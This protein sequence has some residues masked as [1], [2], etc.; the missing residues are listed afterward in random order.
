MRTGKQPDS[1]HLSVRHGA[2]ASRCR[3]PL[4]RA[5]PYVLFACLGVAWLPLFADAQV[6]AAPKLDPAALDPGPLVPAQDPPLPEAV[7]NLLDAPPLPAMLLDPGRRRALLIHQL[8]LLPIQSLA[9]PTL[10][11]AGLRINPRTHGPHA[12][13]A[14]HGLTLVDLDSGES[15]PIA[16]P[17]DVT[18][19]YPRWAPDGSR[20]AFTVTVPT[21]IELWVG[22]APGGTVRRLTNPELNAIRGNPCSW[23]S[24]GRQILCRLASERRKSLPFELTVPTVPQLLHVS[25]LPGADGTSDVEKEFAEYF[26]NSQLELIDVESGARRHIGASTAFVTVDPAPDG[27]LFLVSRMVPPY[28]QLIGVDRTHLVLEI[29]DADGR[30]VHALSP[31]AGDAA[32]GAQRGVRWQASAPATV[33]WIE[34]TEE[35]DR[36]MLQ[37]APFTAP[38]REMFRTQL[39][40]GDLDWLESSSLALVSEYDALRREIHLWLVDSQDQG[41]SPRYLGTR[42]VDTPY[43]GIGAPLTTTNAAGQTVVRVHDNAIYVKGNETGAG[44]SRP[45]L[46]RIGLESFDVERLWESEGRG[47]ERVIDVLDAEGS[48]LITRYE[49]SREPPNYLVRDLSSGDRRPITDHEHPT[50]EL[51]NVSRIPLRYEREDGLELSSIL[52][53]PSDQESEE[54]L[55]LIIWAYPKEYGGAQ[56]TL[57]YAS[58]ERFLDFERAFKL[59]FLLRGYAVLDDVSMPIVGSSGDINSTFVDQVIA[60]ARAAIGAAARTGVVDTDRIGVAGHSYGAFM[61]ANLLAHS[62]LFRAGVAMSGAYN[63]T[64]TPFGFQTEHRTLWEARE[65]YLKM[66]PFLYSDQIDAPLLLVHG[67][68]DDNKGTHPVQSQHLYEAIRRNGGETALLLLPLEGHAYRGR[69]SVL[70]TAAAML[71]WFDRYLKDAHAGHLTAYAGGE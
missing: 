68:L 28:P 6:S 51:Q 29:W 11:I 35:L 12:P 5:R 65:T 24:D 8:G 47:Y 22:E 39:R 18:V 64:L 25:G 38:P 36:V 69:T 34:Q 9:E 27:S 70:H 58:L 48:A 40:F 55:P 4:R 60:N 52:Y 2:F 71:D 67:L 3:V 17:P 49:N 10:T 62:E 13:L 31:A 45:Y 16:L 20:F 63:R 56:P 32:K 66:S 57:S 46:D 30:V 59:F 53:V 42:N 61:V 43:A 50:P 14:Y 37:A 21:G 44:G 54:P 15:I 33:S 1:A 26:L 7:V 19:G 41:E 23:M